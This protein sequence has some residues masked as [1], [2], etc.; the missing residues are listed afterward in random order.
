MSN[1]NDNALLLYG[2][3]FL[4]LTKSSHSH[5]LSTYSK[6]YKLCS[7]SV[8]LRTLKSWRHIL[9]WRL[10]NVFLWIS[11]H[12][13]SVGSGTTSVAL[14]YSNSTQ[15]Q[16]EESD[17]VWTEG[18]IRAVSRADGSGD[19]TGTGMQQYLPGTRKIRSGIRSPWVSSHLLYG[20]K[21]PM[22][23]KSYIWTKHQEVKKKHMLFK[24]Y[25]WVVI[26][27]EI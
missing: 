10:I 15:L 13:A 19:V 16:D 24:Q 21:E 12:S 4:T 18:Q 11:W 1:A 6:T 25:Y 17:N 8:I 3:I 5:L 26:W 2:I 7:D 22:F 27:R 23:K 14:S 20:G 9:K